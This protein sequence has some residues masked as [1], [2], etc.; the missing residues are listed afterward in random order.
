MFPKLGEA[1]IARLATYGKRRQVQA[2]EILVEQGD[3][4]HGVFIVIR[5]SI[6][7]VGVSQGVK[8][9][10]RVLEPGM[11][12]GEVNQLSGRRSLVQSRAREASEVLEI[13]RSRC[14][15]SCRPMRHWARSSCARSCCGG[16]I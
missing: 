6:E 5:G 8:S 12:T 2:G 9:V 14:A 1:Q 3:E 16:C 4:T 13:D 10:L 7:V 11:F 15:A